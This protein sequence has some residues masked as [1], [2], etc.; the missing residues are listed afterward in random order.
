MLLFT[1][2]Q[3]K[4]AAASGQHTNPVTKPQIL[5]LVWV[6]IPFQSLWDH[7]KATVQLFVQVY[8]SGSLLCIE[9]CGGKWH[10]THLF[11]DL[12]WNSQVTQNHKIVRV[13]RDTW[14]SSSPVFLLKQIA[15]I[16][17][18][19]KA[20]R[21]VLNIFREGESTASPDSLL[22]CSVTLRWNK[23]FLMFSWSFLSV[24][25]AFC[26]VTGHCQNELGPIHLTPT[27]QMFKSSAED[28]SP[29]S[30]LNT[31]PG[32]LAFPHKREV[33]GS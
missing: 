31:V 32:L 28:S 16:M 19:R 17:W 2:K 11:K 3:V 10:S 27:L 26:P 23:F 22:Q 13:G 1:Q 24:P 25:V 33:S 30:L 5:L 18:H 29:S 8:T 21:Q 20:S 9:H 6:L 4:G 14:I 15:W 12:V 7:H